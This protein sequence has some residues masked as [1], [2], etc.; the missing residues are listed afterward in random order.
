MILCL[1]VGNSHI[2]GGVFQKDQLLLQ[3]RMDSTQ[4]HS[5]DHYGVFIRNVLRENGC[6]W[7]SIDGIA[8]CSVVPS[9]DYSLIGACKKYLSC[10]PFVL[11]AGTRTGLKIQYHNQLEV[12]SDRIANAIGATRIYPGVP[13]IIVDFGTATTIC[14]IDSDRRYLGGVILPGMKLSMQALQTNTSKLS[15]VPIIV[16]KSILGRSTTESIQAG[17]YWSQR[18]TVKTVTTKINETC[19]QDEMERTRLIGTGGFAH[20]FEDSGIFDNLIPDLVL[21]GLC[22]AF[23]EN[24]FHR[25]ST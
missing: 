13:L 5:S 17:L 4:N 6:A 25:K 1:D 23:Q 12:G 11:K 3:F 14:A 20:L 18:S 9:V 8:L 2:F 15:S 21:Q 10:D 16:P 24:K 19:F 7:N 22:H